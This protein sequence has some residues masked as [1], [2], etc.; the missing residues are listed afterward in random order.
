ML[1]PSLSDSISAAVDSIYDYMI[2]SFF[3]YSDADYLA[4]RA[5]LCP[6]NAVVNDIN[7]TVFKRVP[8]DSRSFFSHDSISKSTDHVGDAD[9]L[10]SL[11]L[12]HATT[13][14]KIPEHERALKVGV[15]VMFLRNV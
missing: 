1:L 7:G 15:P 6:T 3:S 9:L 12:L 8:V 5:I 14:K 2:H 10:F 11:E 4:Q 13:I